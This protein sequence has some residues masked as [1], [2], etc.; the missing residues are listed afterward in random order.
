MQMHWKR[1]KVARYILDNLRNSSD[2]D[3]SDEKQFFLM[4]ALELYKLFQ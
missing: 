4:H 3:E 1:K 2:S